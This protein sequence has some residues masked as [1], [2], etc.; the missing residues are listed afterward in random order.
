MDPT[1]K[2]STNTREQIAF[3]VGVF[4]RKGRKYAENHDAHL[5]WPQKGIYAVIDGSDNLPSAKV[6]AD[7]AVETI[8]QE[9][10]KIPHDVSPEDK[11]IRA[12][13]S[14]HEAI[15][16]AREG[17]GSMIGATGAVVVLDSNESGAFATAGDTRIYVARADGTLEKISKD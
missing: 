6:A 14:T 9:V 4:S 11:A 15:M 1:P 3:D 17:D 5:C 10:F 13:V 16:R 12:L 8:T 2:F 7:L